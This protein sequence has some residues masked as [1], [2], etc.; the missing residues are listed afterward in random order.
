MTYISLL[1]KTQ[2]LVTMLEDKNISIQE[3]CDTVFYQELTMTD[4]DK[5]SKII[6]KKYGKK[7]I[8]YYKFPVL[9][10]CEY[11]YQAHSQCVCLHPYVRPK[12]V[13]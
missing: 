3:I 4:I 2:E 7:E 11:A 8:T 10:D 1:S 5:A 12:F 6:R 9:P 13:L